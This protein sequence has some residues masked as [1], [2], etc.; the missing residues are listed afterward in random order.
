MTRGTRTYIAWLRD[1]GRERE[2]GAAYIAY[3][4]TDW[5]RKTEGDG[6][7]DGC[8]VAP[9]RLSAEVSFNAVNCL[10]DLHTHF[11]MLRLLPGIRCLIKLDAF[12]QPL[13]L[14]PPGRPICLNAT[15]ASKNQSMS[16]PPSVKSS[17]NYFSD[18]LEVRACRCVCVCVCVCVCE[19]Q[20]LLPASLAFYN[21]NCYV[22]IV[23]VSFHYIDIP[24]YYCY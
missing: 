20:V 4:G 15:T 9:I 13:H 21:L 5:S 10:A 11:L 7:K 14:K 12:G 1:G 23:V 8:M 2:G 18:C 22:V 17:V 3:A 6:Q 19:V 24:Y 16:P